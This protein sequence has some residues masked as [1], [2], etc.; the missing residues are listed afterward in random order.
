MTLA[1]ARGLRTAMD[2][3][4]LAPAAHGPAGARGV[5]R[6]V[7][8]AGEQPRPRPH[9][10]GRLPDCSTA[11][12]PG[13]RPAR[14]AP[15]AAAPTCGSRRSVCVPGLSEEQRAGAAQLQSAL[16]HGHPTALAASDLTARAVYLLA[17]GAEPTG[18]VGPA[19]LVRVREPQPLPRALARRPVDLRP[20]PD[21]R[22]LHRPRLGR[23][24]GRPWTGSPRPCAPPPGD[25]PVPGHRRRLDRRGGPR[26]RPAVLPALPRRAGHRPAPGRLHR[27]RLG[28]DRLPRRG[29]R[30]GPPGRRTPGPRSG[31]TASSTG[32]T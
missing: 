22:G 12:A 21:A 29:L 11:T 18:L 13:R 9:L 16:T 7:P 25:R 2:R 1:L 17:Q 27:G 20:R 31:R 5:R 26:H 8:L 23:V 24:P 30:R 15:R 19:A 6:L 28:L 14:S 32:A 10:P 3:G 4:L